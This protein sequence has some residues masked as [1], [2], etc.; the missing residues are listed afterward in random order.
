MSAATPPRG[1][2]FSLDPF[3]RVVIRH[4]AYRCRETTDD[5]HVLVRVDDPEFAEE[6]SHEDFERERKRPDYRL[7]RG[8]FSPGKAKARLHAGVAGILHLPDEEQATVLWRYDFCCTFLRL[9]EAGLYTRSDASMREAAERIEA[10]EEARLKRRRE[11]ERKDRAGTARPRSLALPGPKRFRELLKALEETA[12]DPLSLR[13]GYR[14]C[15]NRTPRFAPEV[16]HLMLVHVGR[17]AS[18][19]RKSMAIHFANLIDDLIDLDNAR[20]E[21]GLPPLDEP[22]FTAFR[23]EINACDRFEV[24]AG[25][26]GLSAAQKRWAV[27][28][29]GPDVVRPLQRVTMDE[30]Q[31]SL[32][33]LAIE[34]GLWEAMSPKLRAQVGRERR[35]LCAALCETTRCFV[36]LRIAPTA[37]SENAIA[38]YRMVVSDKGAYADQVGTLSSWD[39][40]GTPVQVVTDG[41]P[42]FI[43]TAFR[44]AVI[45][46]GSTPTVALGDLPGMRGR[47]ERAFR[48]IRTQLCARFDGHTFE[49]VVALGDYDPTSGAT[50]TADEFCQVLV[51]YVVDIYHNTPHAG[52]GGETPANAWRRVTAMYRPWAPPDSHVR[53]AAFGMRLTRTL[54]PHGVRVLGLRF[55]SEALHAHVRKVG[56]VPADVRLDPYDVGYVSVWVD[57][58]WMAVPCVRDG[59]DG[60]GVQAWIDTLADLRRRYADQ[61]KLT[62]PIVMAALHDIRKI[63]ENAAR[64][65]GIG[66]GMV[67]P[68]QLASA[69]AK[70]GIGFELPEAET[71]GGQEGSGDLLEGGIPT[72]DI[73]AP[74]APEVVP[75][76]PKTSFR[77]ED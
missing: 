10:D 59:F 5:G 58:E 22:G 56:F 28:A 41:G 48:T 31:V 40:V 9:E 18:K 2:G 52:L 26:H 47:V 17:Y 73:P 62:M 4:V 46:T 36:G 72:G 71:A 24:Y 27:V 63:S 11:G 57:E 49:N 54:G 42:S 38:T 15:G 37:S 29:D 6:L 77:F 74:D 67:T 14:R 75:P 68:E 3:D 69:E 35:H 1:S 43:S 53:R 8:Y 12:M 39:M 20:Y 32:M 76:L 19:P 45:T 13:D 16:H 34:A 65:A 44:S 61:A 51:R 66:S 60:V 33:T 70:F 64:R 23:N 50:I 7:E 55:N 30:W 21:K 25:R